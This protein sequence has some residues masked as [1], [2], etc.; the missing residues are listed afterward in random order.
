MTLP[1]QLETHDDVE[2]HLRPCTRIVV[3]GPQR[4]GTTFAATALAHTL[5]LPFMD[6]IEVG[7]GCGSRLVQLLGGERRFVLQAPGMS[8]M[9]HHLPPTPGL[10]VVWMLRDRAEIK[11]SEER[12]GW[13]Q[14]GE[15]DLERKKYRAC[16]PCNLPSIS[17]FKLWHWRSWQTDAI[18]ASCFDLH[19]RSEYLVQH[20]LHVP[21]DERRGWH[22][23]QVERA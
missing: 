20:P 9:L 13:A 12:V 8:F 14:R 3:T 19:Y 6:E 15:G 1:L 17:D 22:I 5:G 10:A 23:K 16:P 18:R 2:Q 7:I 4:S 11:A 21:D